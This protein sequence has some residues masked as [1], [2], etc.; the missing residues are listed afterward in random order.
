MTLSVCCRTLA[1][2]S[3]TC[4]MTVSYLRNTV[5]RSMWPSKDFFPSGEG[6]RRG[7]KFDVDTCAGIL[8]GVRFFYTVMNFGHFGCPLACDLPQCQ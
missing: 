4:C 6:T 5:K 3:T 2:S 8:W 7:H 1:T